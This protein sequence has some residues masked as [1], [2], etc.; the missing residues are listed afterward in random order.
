MR[1]KKPTRD[2]LQAS[3]YLKPTPRTAGAATMRTKPR[4]GA[5]ETLT[6]RTLTPDRRARPG[7]TMHETATST[8]RLLPSE[9]ESVLDARADDGSDSASTSTS[10][11]EK[12]KDATDASSFAV[13]D[14]YLAK[15]RSLRSSDPDGV[16]FV[17]LRRLDRDPTTLDPYAL[18]E[19]PYESLDSKDYYTMSALGVTHFREA[20]DATFVP[21]ERWTREHALFTKTRALAT[22]KKF[23]TWKGFSTWRRVVKQ[24]KMR[25][26]SRVLEKN[27]FFLD[28]TLVGAMR[29]VRG[30]CHELSKARLSR[31]APGTLRTLEAFTTEARETREEM[32]EKL[33]K[34]SDATIEA[35]DAACAAALAKMEKSLRDFF[36]GEAPARPGS[37]ETPSSSSSPGEKGARPSAGVEEYAYT[38][39]ATRRTE[40]RRLLSFVKQLDYLIRDTLRF[41]LH[42]SMADLLGATRQCPEDKFET[43]PPPFRQRLSNMRARLSYSRMIQAVGRRIRAQ[44]ARGG[45]NKSAEIARCFQEL[46]RETIRENEYR[47]KEDELN[48]Y[49]PAF[50]TAPNFELRL[51]IGPDQTLAFSPPAETFQSEIESAVSLFAETLAA[52]RRLPHDSK[53]M[54]KMAAAA[55][56]DESEIGEVDTAVE[57]QT[58]EKHLGLT[59][60][61]KRSL[62][63]GFETATEYRELYDVFRAMA[64]ANAAVDLEVMVAEYRAGKLT[65]DVFRRKTITFLDQRTRIEQMR[66]D[67]DVGI[68]RI[69]SEA[70]RDGLLPSPVAKLEQ[71]SEVLPK[72][73]AD[74]YAEFIAEVHDSTQR[75]SARL[76]VAQELCDRMRFVS[77]LRNGHMDALNRRAEECANIYRLVREF[78][79][80]VDEAAAAEFATL[81][82][83]FNLLK[84]VLEE[85]EGT[86]EEKISQFNVELEDRVK[87]VTREARELVKAASDEM[88]LDADAD[89]EKVLK[90]V[91]DLTARCEAQQAEAKKINT[92]QETFGLPETEFD[93]LK[94]A[95]DDV[96]LKRGMWEGDRDFDADVAVWRETVFDR[97]D[98][99]TMEAKM[100][101]YTKLSTRLERGLAPNKMSPK[102]AAK[103]DDYKNLL[104]VINALLN[105]S[106]KTRHW[107]KVQ[108]L[109]GVPIVRDDAFTLQKILD[110]KAPAHGDAIGLI[111][112]EATQ[113]QALEEMLHKVTAKWSDVCFSVVAYKESKDTFILGGIEE[114][115]VALEDS[116]VTMSTIMSSRFVKGIRET[117]EKVEGQL[118]LFGET[119]DEWLAVQKNW[120]YLETIFSAPDIQRQLPAEAKQFFAVD[121]QFRDVM[122]KTR[123][124]DNALRAGTTPGYL[125]SFQNANESLDRIQKNLEEYLE[126][127]RM[128]FPRFY[129]LSNDELLEILAQT[130]NVQAVQ[131]HMSKCF[132]GIKSLDFGSDPKSVDI[133]AMCSPEG[134]RVGL[135]KNLKA[136]GNVEQW[137]GAVETAMILSLQ[138]QGKESYVSY[139]RETRTEWVLNQPAQVVIMVSQ[140]YWCR[141]V[142]AALESKE[143]TNSMHLYL[144]K[145]RGDLKDMTVVVRGKLSGLHRKII[146]ALITIDVHAR[147]IV[148]ELYDARTASTND[149]KWQMQ[150]RYYWNDDDDVCVVRQTNSRFEYAYE[151][152]GAQS[153]LV[154]T[155]MTDRC[156]MTLTGAMHLKL[157]GAPAGPAGTGKTESTKDL[158]KA[159]GVQCVVFNCGDNLD[160]K[161]MG[162]FFAGLAQCGAWACFDEFNRIDIE[163]LSVVA[164][165]LLTIQN[166]MKSGVTKF[167]FEGREMK[168]VHTFAVFITMNPGY[169][170]RTE[171]PDN[172]KALFRPMAM[173]IPDYALVAEVMLFSEG[174]ETSKDLSRKMVKLYKLSSEQLSQQDHYDFGMRALKSVLVMAGSLKR[175]SPDLDEQV[176]LIRAMRDS[177]L[178]KFLSEDAELFEAIVSDLFPGV[179]VPEVE[180]GDLARAIIE[181]LEEHELQNV[182]KFVLKV[183]QMY[184]TFNVRFG[185]MLVGPTGGGKTTVYRMLQSALTKLRRNGH[186]NDNFQVIHT[187]VFN[188]KCIKMGELYGEYNLMTNEWTDG[189]GSTLIR[190]AVADTTPDKKWVVFDGPVDAIWIE[191]MNTVLDDNCTLCLPNGERIKLNPGTMRML[192][193]VQDLAVASPA[194]VSRCG[195][196][197]VPPE[198]L[199]WRPFVQTWS[200]TKLHESAPEDLREW[201]V[202]LFDKTVDAGLKFL[203]KHLK[204]GIPSVDINLVASLASL[205]QSLARPER[206]V[207]LA[208][209]N[210]KQLKA[211]L[212]KL[213]AFSYVWSVGGNV[214]A[215]FHDRFDEWAREFLNANVD[216]LGNLPNKNTLYDYYVVTTNPEEPKGRFAPWDDLVKKFAYNPNTPYFELLVPNVDTTRFSFLLERC[217]EVDKSLLLTG[218][219]GVGKSVIIVDYLAKHAEEKDLVPVVINFSAQ[220][221]AYDTQLLIE[222]KLEKK[223]QDQVRRA[224]EQ[225]NRALRG[226]RQHARARDVRRAASRRAFTAVPGLQGL[227]R[228]QEA[229][230]EGRRGHDFDLRVR[231]SGRRAPGGDAAFLQALQHAERPAALRREHEDHFKQHLRRVPRGPG[232]VPGRLLRVRQ[233]RG[234]RVGG[235]VPSH[236]RGAPADAR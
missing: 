225:K 105:E 19:C 235:G 129:F 45:K 171:L 27:L 159:L 34:F 145:N 117:V 5:T 57:L 224:P 212:A 162:K 168:L 140:I 134:E 109:I 23:R 76:D 233:A 222:S 169:A 103:V 37:E 26:A 21:Y 28:S 203:R 35:V 65:L 210:Q 31:I 111:S 40:Q 213:F 73:A 68:V 234:G 147:D 202:G 69:D 215:Q 148:E 87:E 149:F 60:D 180:Q 7:E 231:A 130:K 196:V 116:M 155:P 42:D 11:D 99:P 211:C 71:M 55:E 110:L 15:M 86:Q 209:E 173:M 131:P 20:Q 175:G 63:F 50:P 123:E 39:T 54:A 47:K 189:L 200:K 156:Y 22:F 178:P 49:A 82:K 4:M 183:V 176:V 101:R 53:L 157:G 127:K 77:E 25:R 185:A 181:S 190:N 62:R 2:A 186:E 93:A 8:K 141:G 144:E 104:P 218:G 219:T 208:M 142:V 44:N 83:D 66:V 12:E 232:R 146:A 160:Y 177:N 161:F 98:L 139:P 61:V 151:Y 154:V 206:G 94:E 221:P 102:F 193:E 78:E 1:T 17:Y 51:E 191:N 59:A 121:K 58:D 132:D 74:V 75:L 125:Q 163:V 174:F 3:L 36:G 207:N 170:G 90:F 184:E 14:E 223:A 194:T 128:A 114:I 195:M 201:I 112:T 89:R 52:T 135:G 124:N 120:M 33:E 64:A 214:D 216:G 10:G 137:L 88:I 197:Y 32:L 187:Y 165:Q 152:L 227:L 172:L 43:P 100:G 6:G 41:V 228:P 133:F 164:Q 48:A 13:G 179:E 220:T 97:I 153:R 119:L 95:V 229:L 158:G 96:A 24:T 136:R 81:E 230:L 236:V 113:E 70:F 84:T 138:K 217:L 38:V 205:F 115:M 150:L 92:I 29:A 167:I 30:E 106:M 126:T 72:L 79:F 143:P 122:R 107:D 192:F 80:P 67:A 16:H 91:G 204:E 199:G 108:E 166:A 182:D 198:E 18:A 226:R 85:A 56:A 9:R 118:G 46:V 188:P